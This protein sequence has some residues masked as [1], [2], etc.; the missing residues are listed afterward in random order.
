MPF[1]VQPDIFKAFPGLHLPVAIA[2]HI[3]NQHE[4]VAIA[5]QWREVWMAARAASVY[6]NAQ[7]HPRVQPWRER[8]RQLGVSGKEFPSSI[9]TLRRRALKGGEPFH[10]N[11]LV[12][13][14]NTISL[15]HVVPA[16]GFDLD[17]IHGLLELRFTRA[18]D[19][20]VA[21]DEQA[22]I[23]VAAGE[24]AYADGDTVLTRHF[25]WRQAKTALIT[26]STRYVF[27]VAEVLGE[28]GREVAEAVLADFKSGLQDFFGVAA[29][30]FLVNQ[31]QPSVGWT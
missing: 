30:C 26:P 2:Q 12:D 6:H 1:I 15:R 16:G 13:F 19:T 31:Q 28:V 21:L 11:P 14:C 23:T 17:A 5:A 18:G 25:V 10:I 24:A 7:S 9:E 3:N 27:L 22:P 4:R 8:F 29:H 20:F